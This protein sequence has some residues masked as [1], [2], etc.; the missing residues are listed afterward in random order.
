MS[1]VTELN[2]MEQFTKVN[3]PVTIPIP[4]QTQ[5]NLRILN[6]E[7]LRLEQQ[8]GMIMGTLIEAMGYGEKQFTAVGNFEAL[9]EK[10]D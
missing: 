10:E 9:V 2:N 3:S 4:P 7:K 6:M 1:K 8:M 5:N